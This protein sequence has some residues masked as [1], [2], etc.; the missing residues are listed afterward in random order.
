MIE[1]IIK[2]P[3]M[4]VSLTPQLENFVR[5]KVASGFYN[6]ASE[7]IREALRM[8]EERERFN[9]LKREVRKGYDQMRRGEVVPYDLEAIEAEARADT[10][11]GKPINPLVCPADA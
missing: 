6:N 3:P 2:E 5:E 9:L 8:L 7:V 10:K 4:N 11:A 1:L